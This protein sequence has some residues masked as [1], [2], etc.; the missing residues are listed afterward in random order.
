MRANTLMMSQ[1]FQLQPPY[2]LYSLKTENHKS[3]PHPTPKNPPK[4]KTSIFRGIRSTDVQTASQPLWGKQIN[5]KRVKKNKPEVDLLVNHMV[6][7]QN[8]NI[9]PWLVRHEY[10]NQSSSESLILIDTAKTLL[11]NA[12]EVIWIFSWLMKTLLIFNLPFHDLF[13]F[14]L[15]LA[16]AAVFSLLFL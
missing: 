12:D 4:H 13:I 3:S 1:D 8:E 10:K 7:H 16:L 6:V 15:Q 11:M 14:F 2:S 9:H 5:E